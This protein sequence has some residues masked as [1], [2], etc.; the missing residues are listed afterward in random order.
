MTTNVRSLYD[1][2]RIQAA[3]ADKGLRLRLQIAAPELAS[4]PWEFLYDVRQR[5]YLCRQKD[6]PLVRYLEVAAPIPTLTVNAPL[7]I[8]AMIASPNDLHALDTEREKR[9][10]EQSLARLTQTG[11][12]E[13]VWV[14]SGHW[15]DLQRALWHGPW[16]VFHYIGHGGFDTQADEGILA[17]EGD[18]GRMQPIRARSLAD[19]LAGERSLRFAFLNACLGVAGGERDV[20]A[21][22]AATL[23]QRGTPAVLAMQYEITDKAAIEFGQTFYEALAEG[24]PVDT[25]ATMARQAI[26]FGVPNSLEWGTPVLY[27]RATSGPL[28]MVNAPTQDTVKPTQLEVVPPLSPMSTHDAQVRYHQARELYGLQDYIGAVSELKALQAAGFKPRVGSLE[29]LINEI[30]PLLDDQ[31]RQAECVSV[32]AELEHEVNGARSSG[33]KAELRDALAQFIADCAKYGDPS[34]LAERLDPPTL[35]QLQQRLLAIMLDS[36][37]PPTERAKAGDDINQHGDPRPGVIDFNFDTDYWCK[38]P[39]GPF[40]MGSDQ[41]SDNKKREKAI[42][43]DYWIAKYPITYV[44]YKTFLDDPNGYRSAQYWKDLHA[45]GLAQQGKGAGDQQWNI[46]NRPAENVSWYDA[47]AFCAWLNARLT[48]E[49]ALKLE[50]YSFRLP[51]EVEWEKAARGTDGREY[52]YSGEFDSTQGNT[53]ESGIGQT[54]TVGVFPDGASPYGVTDISGNVWEWTL[55]EYETRI[56]NNISNDKYRTLRGGSWINDQ[57]DARVASRLFFPP[58]SRGAYGGFRLVLAS[59][60]PSL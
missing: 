11:Q 48:L 56:N 23:V 12:I 47:M 3:N 22:T 20:F 36:K 49:T 1:G 45:D 53:H 4:L 34:G 46:A 59:R 54:S 5:V 42:P 21:S 29:T 15:R 31:Q 52:P 39:A 16:H 44:Q 19:L 24:L 37:R 41:D 9:R 38:V 7:R 14:D 33:R 57:D 35:G 10:M 40:T 50:G 32:Y 58:D 28:F 43:Y 51:T 6:T 13:L 2:S 60:P 26:H 8:L 25:A 17:F 27:S 30:Q 18:D 55:T